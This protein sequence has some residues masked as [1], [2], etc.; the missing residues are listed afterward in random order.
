LLNVKLVGASRNQKVKGSVHK[1]PTTVS[2]VLHR[3]TE[4]CQIENQ[5]SGSTTFH[6]S[7]QVTIHAINNCE[8]FLPVWLLVRTNTQTDSDSSTEE[9]NDKFYDKSIQYASVLK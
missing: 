7:K 4:G 6:S 9:Q 5:C 3:F 8:L 2:H 1:A